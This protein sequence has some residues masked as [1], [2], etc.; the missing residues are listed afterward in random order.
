MSFRHHDISVRKHLHWM[1]LNQLCWCSLH[2]LPHVYLMQWEPPWRWQDPVEAQIVLLQDTPLL[3]WFRY[4]MQSILNSAKLCSHFVYRRI[5]RNDLSVLV[6]FL[7][8]WWWQAEYINYAS[9]REKLCRWGTCIINP[10]FSNSWKLRLKY[11]YPHEVSVLRGG[12][13]DSFEWFKALY[14]SIHIKSDKC[15]SSRYLLSCIYSLKIVTVVHRFES[16][17]LPELFRRL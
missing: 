15:T 9:L 11:L 13:S 16:A 4:S 6:P 10:L 17:S 2:H 7:W 1:V 3:D 12:R 8:S 5:T 14:K